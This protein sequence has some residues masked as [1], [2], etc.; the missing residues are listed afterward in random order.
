MG[1]DSTVMPMASLQDLL[2]PRL[3]RGDKAAEWSW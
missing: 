3:Y 2:I 1:F